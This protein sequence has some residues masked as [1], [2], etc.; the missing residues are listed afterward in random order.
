MTNTSE[1]LGRELIVHLQCYLCTVEF[2]RAGEKVKRRQSLIRSQERC[3]GPGEGGT[4][5]YFTG[6]DVNFKQRFSI[7]KY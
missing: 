1:L 3:R 6:Y 5:I 2:S 4:I 7:T